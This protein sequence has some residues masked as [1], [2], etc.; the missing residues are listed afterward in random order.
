MQ[1]SVE[2]TG[3]LERSVTVDVPEERI[4][5]AVEERLKSMSRTSRIQG[6]RPGKAPLRVIKQRFGAQ[7]RK[8]VVEKLV[9]SSFYEAVSKEDLKPVG[10]PLIDPLQEKVGEGLSYT[11]TFEVLPE[12]KL[13]PV[14]DL[15]IE[16]P[17]CPITDADVDGM[18]DKLRR[19]R[20]DFRVEERAAREGDRVNVNCRG[21]VDGE[22]QDNLKMGD[23][24]I[25][26]GENIFIPGFEEGLIGAAAGQSLT[27]NLTFPD[28][29]NN[30]DLA[31]KPVV[32][33]LEVNHVAESVL[34]ELDEEFF[35]AFGVKEGGEQAFRQE[36]R[37]HM[38][39]EVDVASR[40]R[41]RDATMQSLHD[42]NE[43][44]V[45]NTLVNAEFERMKGM[46]VKD[47]EMR[48]VAK[49]V[50]AQFTANEELRNTA[51]RQV[52][53]QLLTAEIISSQELRA[54][55]EKVR[56]IIEKRAQSYEDSAS[57]INWYYNDKERLAEIEALALEDEVINWI[58]TRGR[59][60]EVPLSF[61]E[62]MNKGQ[63][64]QHA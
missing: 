54:S 60:K 61:D 4:S 40:T 25:E 12:F 10:R 62:L 24:D 36:I 46:L 8:E 59:V 51:R 27:L 35:E 16:K 31:G 23:L 1:V 38:E 6:F 37:R 5:S 56:E 55:P 7:V 19:Q 43:I 11:A 28:D 20:R 33:E 42:A 32:F 41:L 15:E 48:G 22:A 34:P 57:L 17:V 2:T 21:L 18:I 39:R 30:E 3:S 58:S 13:N 52:A 26:I 9:T 49:E 14:E 29:Y 44:E 53:L 45:P 63:T 47:M 64:Q 50:A